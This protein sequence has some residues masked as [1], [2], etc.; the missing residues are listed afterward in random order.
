MVDLMSAP[1]LFAVQSTSSA[2][3]PQGNPI[4][5]EGAQSL[6]LVS[7]DRAGFYVVPSA[8]RSLSSLSDSLPVCDII[9]L[10]TCMHNR[11]GMA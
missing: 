6:A 3:T 8:T 2:P 4:G 7:T 11:L 5:D 10:M 9:L 1:P